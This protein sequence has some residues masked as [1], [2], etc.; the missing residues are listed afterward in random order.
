MAM[1]RTDPEYGKADAE[2]YKIVVAMAE[3]L[4][5]DVCALVMGFLVDIHIE[6]GR[7]EWKNR[8]S[9]INIEYRTVFKKHDTTVRYSQRVKHLASGFFFNYRDLNIR[10][11]F[12][13]QNHICHIN[14]KTC[15]QGVVDLISPHYLL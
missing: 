9:A 14:M 13:R 6:K 12:G 4:V 10:G 15:K 7:Q 11:K 5:P 8:V 3:N 2:V 1:N